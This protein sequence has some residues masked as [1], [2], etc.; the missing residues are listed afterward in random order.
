MSSILRAKERFDGEIDRIVKANDKFTSALVGS[1]GAFSAL[2]A[3]DLMDPKYGELGTVVGN[4]TLTDI[5]PGV[6]AGV[7]AYAAHQAWP[8]LEGKTAGNLLGQVGQTTEKLFDKFTESA[9]SVMNSL[10]SVGDM[11]GLSAHA[12]ELKKDSDFVKSILRVDS[13]SE[14]KSIAKNVY[15][16]DNANAAIHNAIRLREG[17]DIAV[18]DKLKSGDRTP[19]SYNDIET[20]VLKYMDKHKMLGVSVEEMKGHDDHVKNAILLVANANP[21]NLSLSASGDFGKIE[22]SWSLNL[23]TERDKNKD[24]PSLG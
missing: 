8:Y 7:A 11:L 1:M 2:I 5:M 12:R 22:K 21:E 24:A 10:G 19:L 9:K 15:G 14:V 3:T 17:I 20:G 13:M 4:M 16:K 18:K 6:I 23:L